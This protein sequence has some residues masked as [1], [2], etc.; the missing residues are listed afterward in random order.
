M[1]S[2][3]T[4]YTISIKDKNGVY[5]VKPFE[6]RDKKLVSFDKASTLIIQGGFIAVK[7]HRYIRLLPKGRFIYTIRLLIS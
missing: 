4:D 5:F 2:L 7:Y 1:E 3:N 6:G